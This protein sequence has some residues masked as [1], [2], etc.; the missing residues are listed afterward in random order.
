MY[1]SN[2][3]NRFRNNYSDSEIKLDA[4]EKREVDALVAM[5]QDLHFTRSAQVSNY[6]RA[7]KLGFKFPHISGYLEL[8]RGGDD[9]WEFEG[10]IKP[11]F[12]A[13]VCQRLH[14]DDNRSDARVTGFESYRDRWNSNRNSEGTI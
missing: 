12:Y 5:F 9:T 1:Y 4:D 11:K 13:A 14:L 2:Y 6:I 3:C 7:H 10:G 8:T